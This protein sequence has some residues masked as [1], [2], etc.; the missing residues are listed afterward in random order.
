MIQ[1]IIEMRRL[2]NK[3]ILAQ[4]NAGIPE[5]VDGNLHY[6]ETPEMIAPKVL[7]LLKSGV[8]ILGGCC[9]TTPAHIKKMREV[10][11]LFL[12]SHI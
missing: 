2:T 7:E 3:P 8:N 6:I 4:S 12:T 9:G 5:L 1:V 11:D 10:L